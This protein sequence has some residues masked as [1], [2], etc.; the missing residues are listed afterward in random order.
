[1]KADLIVA[2]IAL[3]AVLLLAVPVLYPV[4]GSRSAVQGAH[5]IFVSATGSASAIP[6]EAR[7]SLSANGTGADAEAAAANLSETIS[8]VN[9][10]LYNYVN[11]NQS[12]I[13]TTYYS[14]RKNTC[15][16][17]Y[18]SRPYNGTCNATGYE[19]AESLTVTI[20]E[21]SNASAA[22]AALSNISS[23]YIENVNAQFSESQLSALKSESLKKALLNATG[24]AQIVAGNATVSVRNITI[25]SYPV[26][27]IFYGA[28]NAGSAKSS[29]PIIFSGSSSVVT[30]ISAAFSYT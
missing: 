17:I 25:N 8:L 30:S 27:P 14:V 13:S 16:Y 24:Q 23:V 26:Y 19:A 29:G 9:K 20:P 1:M 5:T 6:S 22:A 3:V 10:T 18:A 2:I 28:V 15:N 11:G 4:L 7:I 21:F 12:L